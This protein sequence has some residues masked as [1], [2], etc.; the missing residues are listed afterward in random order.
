MSIQQVAEGFMAEVSATPCLEWIAIFFA[1][2]EVL[3]ARNNNVLLYP[4]GILST[5]LFTYI[6]IQPKAGLYADAI[7]NVY[8]LV[9]SIYG[10]VL[11]SKRKKN[12]TQLQISHN[13]RNDWAVTLCIA[14][15]G[16]GV[17]YVL[18]TVVFPRMFAGY[19]IS[20]VAVWD[21]LISATAWA[22]MWLL[23]KRKIEN[24]LLLNIS[25]IVAIPVYMY[26][27]MPFTAC[28]TLFL[29][30][31]AVIG[32]YDWRKIYNLNERLTAIDKNLATDQQ[33]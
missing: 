7:L 18:L 1:I 16:W 11:W 17:L 33:H 15:G 13:T 5:I 27:G 12:G 28:L 19:V 3:L 23:A 2:A 10:W 32:Y 8:Y 30:V 31:I 21:A 4:A 24:W 20:D 9:M 22:G 26:K 25:N 29:F 6:F 14:I